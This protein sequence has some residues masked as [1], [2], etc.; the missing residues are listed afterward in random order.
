MRHVVNV[1]CLCNTIYTQLFFFIEKTLLR[2]HVSELTA[3]S[4]GHM[5]LR[6]LRYCS[7]FRLSLRCFKER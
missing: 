7:D 6:R 5:S 2:R 1:K 3:P 4:S